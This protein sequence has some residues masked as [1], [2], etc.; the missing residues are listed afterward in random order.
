MCQT[1]NVLLQKRA[2]T[3]TRTV[4]FFTSVLSPTHLRGCWFRVQYV[5]VPST[6]TLSPARRA[7]AA[8]SSVRPGLIALAP[9]RFWVF[10]RHSKEDLSHYRRVNGRE[11][12][13]R[14]RERR[15]CS[16]SGFRRR[17]VHNATTS[18]KQ[19]KK[20]SSAVWN[21]IDLGASSA[22]ITLSPPAVVTRRSRT[23]DF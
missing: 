18:A 2:R 4:F 14:K 13:E 6:C 19:K 3:R 1:L 8:I 22:S 9:Q 12:D 20:T 16:S 5:L 11:R 15:V 17:N 23:T 10:S 21:A 7:T